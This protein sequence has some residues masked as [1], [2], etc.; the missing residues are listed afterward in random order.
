MYSELYL[1]GLKHKYWSNIIQYGNASENTKNQVSAIMFE[2]QNG[3]SPTVKAQLLIS[4]LEE[5]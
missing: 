2:E 3:M 1:Y 4:E 5:L